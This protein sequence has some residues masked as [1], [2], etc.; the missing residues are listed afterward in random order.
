M[1]P[2][3]SPRSAQV[4]VSMSLAAPVLTLVATMLAA[5]PAAA[6]ARPPAPPDSIPIPRRT[7]AM[8]QDQETRTRT[9]V[10]ALNAAINA[11]DLAALQRAVT[12]DVVFENTNPAPD[13]TRVEGRQAFSGFFEKWFAA[14]PDARFEVE[15]LVV[16]GDRAVVRWIYRKTRDGRPWHIRG[17][18]LFRVRDGRV[19]EKLSYVKG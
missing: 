2:V 12:D 13:G 10:E 14:N 3:A 18:D 1:R 6:E 16:A 9:A 15:E 4:E 7:P 19:A 5:S 8:S 17:I 11:H